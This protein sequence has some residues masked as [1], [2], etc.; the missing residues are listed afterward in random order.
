MNAEDIDKLEAGRQLDALIAE[1]VM[2]WIWCVQVNTCS[3]VKTELGKRSRFLGHPD[4]YRNWYEKWDGKEQL[5]ID[6]HEES[7]FGEYSSDIAAAWEVV[8]MFCAD[9][10]RLSLYY[11]VDG[12]ICQLHFE[13]DSGRL[14]YA[15]A[16]AVP[17][18]I[19]RAALKALSAQQTTGAGK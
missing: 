17:L 7:A 8:E 13:G 15:E 6:I 5:P 11:P 10:I 19:C 16:K 1:K 4:R 2:G 9:D 18:A 14:H 3:P 12:D